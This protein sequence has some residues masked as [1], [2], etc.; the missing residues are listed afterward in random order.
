MADLRSFPSPP[1][2]RFRKDIVTSRPSD[3]DYYMETLRKSQW[4]ISDISFGAGQGV[5]NDKLAYAI[6]PKLG[7]VARLEVALRRWTDGLR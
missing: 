1:K 5:I 2:C 3:A 7:P 6:L 4:K